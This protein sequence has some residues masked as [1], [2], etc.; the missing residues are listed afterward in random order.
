MRDSSNNT[1]IINNKSNRAKI[2]AKRNRR[3]LR[4]PLIGRGS[5]NSGSSNEVPRLGIRP[6][7]RH[8]PWLRVRA[9]ARTQILKPMHQRTPWI[10]RQRCQRISRHLYRLRRWSRLSLPRRSPRLRRPRHPSHQAQCVFQYRTAIESIRQALPRVLPPLHALPAVQVVGLRRGL[11][12]LFL[13]TWMVLVLLVLTLLLFRRHHRRHPGKNRRANRVSWQRCLRSGP[14]P[15]RRSSFGRVPLRPRGEEGPLHLP[16]PTR[17]TEMAVA[18]ILSTLLT[19]P[20]A[21]AAPLGRRAHPLLVVPVRRKRSSWWS[22]RDNLLNRHLR[23]RHRRR[24][25]RDLQLRNECSSIN[26]NSERLR[27]FP[28]SMPMIGIEASIFSGK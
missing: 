9:R 26:Q 11:G 14:P 4:E 24:R 15:P 17:L 5:R 22:V 28:L 10:P 13:I 21:L 27:P 20:S 19:R 23:R 1:S 6:T 3:P 18:M 12:L 25:H 8:R 7:T 16:L 2:A